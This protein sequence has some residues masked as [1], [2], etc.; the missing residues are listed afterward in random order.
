MVRLTEIL[1]CLGSSHGVNVRGRECE[2]EAC[3][4]GRVCAPACP[5]LSEAV[6]RRPDRVWCSGTWLPWRGVLPQ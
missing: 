5:R 2:A 3:A 4:C 6:C 1:E